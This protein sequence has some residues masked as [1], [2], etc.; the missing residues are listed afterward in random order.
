MPGTA[1]GAVTKWVGFAEKDFADIGR[2]P[3]EVLIVPSA[4]DCAVLLSCT[5]GVGLQGSPG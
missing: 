4:K 2:F 5:I 1:L 3:P